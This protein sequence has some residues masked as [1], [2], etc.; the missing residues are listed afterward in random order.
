MS[1]RIKHIPSYDQK[2]K[3][4]ETYAHKKI[5]AWIIQSNLTYSNPDMET[6]QR[7]LERRTG[8]QIVVIVNTTQQ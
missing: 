8:K 7:S 2:W 5:C 6:A 3:E 4:N 1:Y